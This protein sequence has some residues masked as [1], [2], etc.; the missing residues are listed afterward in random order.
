MEIFTILQTLSLM[1]YFIVLYF[2][3]SNFDFWTLLTL[4]I[5]LKYHSL[6][7]NQLFRSYVMHCYNYTI[8]EQAISTSQWCLGQYCALNF[9]KYS[10]VTKKKICMKMSDIPMTGT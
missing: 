3:F 5:V 1:I 10:T 8:D 4:C 9:L 6:T 7:H 2:V